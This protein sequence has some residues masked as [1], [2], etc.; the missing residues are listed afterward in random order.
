MIS[1]RHQELHVLYISYSCG[2]VFDHIHLILVLDLV[3]VQ[4]VACL[5]DLDQ[6][7]HIRLSMADRPIDEDRVLRT[8]LASGH[9]LLEIRVAGVRGLI[10]RVL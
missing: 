9:A 2:Y 5:I 3:L 1:N 6:F 10:S 4:C 8:P 7:L